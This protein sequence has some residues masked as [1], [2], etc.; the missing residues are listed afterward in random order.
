M[1]SAISDPERRF[2]IPGMVEIVE[3]HGG[4]EK[5]RITSPACQADMYL[6][7]AH[8]T[9]W[10]PAEAEEV[11]FL[12]SRSLWED[13]RAIRGGIP[14]CFPWFAHK[15]DQPG[16]PDHG[17]VRTRAWRLESISRD[18]DA[19]IV[20]MST[21]SDEATKK[22]WPADFHM[23]LRASFSKELSLELRVTNTG[24][25]PLQFEEAL[26]AY[27]RV[28]NIETTR[29][30][31]ADALNYIDKVDFHRVKMQRG[32]IA[33]SS[34]TDRVYLHTIDEIVLED[35]LLKRRLRVQKEHSS[36][37]VAWNPWAEKASSMS[38]LGK[39]EWM[40]MMCI[41][42]SN[43]SSFAVDLGPGQQHHMKMQVRVVDF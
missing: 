29:A 5:V 1:E 25:M 38:D 40:R 9:S 18:R 3:G 20:T 13:G 42:P 2:A 7:G 21:E 31:I 39:D 11:L 4:L 8:I 41:E 14:V 26:H 28:G 23:V 24:D 6:H 36:T 17:F 27:F 34:E 35:P 16:A 33:I 10:K 37:T 32:D 43:V 12:S 22:W 30:R 19:I 15:A